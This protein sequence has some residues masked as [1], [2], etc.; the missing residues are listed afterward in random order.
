MGPAAMASCCQHKLVIKEN[1]HIQLIIALL[2]HKRGRQPEYRKID[3]PV[4]QRRQSQSGPDRANRFH[5]QG[6]AWIAMEKSFHDGR[7]HGSRKRILACEP[8]FTRRRI[9]KEL[10][11]FHDLLEFVE[12]RLSEFE[13]STT[14]E[15]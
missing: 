1:L 12:Y 7:E 4:V 6:N 11:V 3:E 2:V 8:D 9:R 15:C 13:Q 10:D 5:A 14:L